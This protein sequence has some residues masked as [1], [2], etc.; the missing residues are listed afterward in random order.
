MDQGFAG[1]RPPSKIR[2]TRHGSLVLD[3]QFRGRIYL[4]SLLLECVSATPFKFC[5]NFYRGQVNRTRPRLHSPR[6]EAQT[7]AD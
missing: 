6:E 3:H 4:K 5:Y 1:P 2:R 7:L